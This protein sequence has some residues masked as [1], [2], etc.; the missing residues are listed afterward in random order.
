MFELRP[1]QRRFLRD[2]LA[3]RIRTAALSLARGNGKTSLSARLAFESLTPGSRLFERG[4]ENHLVANSLGQ[5]RRTSFG[6]LRRMVEGS[7]RAGEYSIAES[8]QAAVIAHKATKTK[9]SVLPASGRSAMGLVN[10]RLLIADEPASWKE[11]D[12]L[13]MHEAIQGAI[14]KPGSSLRVLY[15]GTRAPAPD[16]HWWPSLVAAGC[17]G[18]THVTCY[19]GKRKDWDQW[20][21]IQKA[22]PL[23]AAFAES[24]RVLLEERDKAR[25]DS[26]LKA[27][28]LSYRLN[29]PTAD[30]ARVLITVADWQR[31]MRCIPPPREGRPVVGADVG[32]GRAWS[33][34]VAVWPNGRTECAAIAPGVP[35]IQDQEKRD[36]VTPGTYRR[37]VDQGSLMVAEGLRVPPVG[38]LLDYVKDWKPKAIVCDRFRL[39]DLLD[40][41]PRCRVIPRISRWSESTEDIRALRRGCLD[42]GLT[43]AMGSRPLLKASL[44]VTRV[45][46]DDAGNCRLLKQGSNNTARDDVCAA[47]VLAAGAAARMKPRQ[48]KPKFRLVG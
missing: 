15:V 9:I 24:R 27:A 45:L 21:N 4:A 32:A 5:A 44:S 6:V 12:G 7:D 17:C 38:L 40:A 11:R 25:A 33:S 31:L 35:D 10:C 20:R 2:A 22:N 39:S 13:L 3:P 18:S 29:L 1:F 43:V 23:M 36:N 34:A 8:T 48:N 16:N 37:L 46:N 19:Q 42:G 47:W 28:F 30:A 26:R 14:G 41:E